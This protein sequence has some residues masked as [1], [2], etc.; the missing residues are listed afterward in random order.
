VKISVPKV[1][2]KVE[3]GGNLVE[4]LCLGSDKERQVTACFGDTVSFFLLSDN[5]KIGD[6][7]FRLIK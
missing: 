5:K 3:F 4:K 1:P 6:Y 7:G 2:I